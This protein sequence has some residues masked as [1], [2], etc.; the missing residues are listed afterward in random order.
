[1]N[2][3]NKKVA[4]VQSN[5]IPWKGY[6]DL[7][8]S[9][10]EFILYDDMQFTK[11]DWRN[12]NTI[13]SNDS[14]LWLTVP[15]R[16][17]GKYYQTIKDT[18]VNDR[19]WARKHWKSITHS[20]NKAKHFDLYR[21]RFEDLFLNVNTIFLSAINYLFITTNCDILNIT[22]KISW[23]MDYKLPREGRTERLIDLCKQASG[24]EYI[25]GPAAKNYMDEDTFREN[26]L[27]LTYIDY[28]DYP[29]YVQLHPPFCHQVSVIDL[30]LNEGPSAKK[31]MKSFR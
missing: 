26:G 25:S 24:T 6:F 16:V 2:D 1:M 22:T 10:D 28:S 8:N 5:Y 11:R 19:D 14:L 13:K 3:L 4:I 23:S 9:V 7:I 30:I 31:Y 21:E 27:R 18:E 17:K 15:V 12:R 20:Y 29:E